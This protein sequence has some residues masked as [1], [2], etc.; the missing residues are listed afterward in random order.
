KTSI[1]PSLEPG[2]E[3]RAASAPGGMQVMILGSRRHVRES[4]VVGWRYGRG[5]ALG[6]L[7]SLRVCTSITAGGTRVSATGCSGRDER[8]HEGAGPGLERLGYAL[9][10]DRVQRGAEQ[11]GACI[12]VCF[13]H[14]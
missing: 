11:P 14:V 3:A 12:G 10:K 5:I 2:A 1:G 7:L 8:G 9:S 6:S 4:R 13:P